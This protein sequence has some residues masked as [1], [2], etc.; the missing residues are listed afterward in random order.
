MMVSYLRKVLLLLVVPCLGLSV[1]SAENPDI[2]VETGVMMKTRDGVML[3]TD[4]YRPRAEGKYPVILERTSY[5]KQAGIA[6]GVKAAARGYVY[7]A[8]D[9]RGRWTSGGDGQN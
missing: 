3:S 7:I 1:W 2:K 5:G 8:Q 6:F 4:I 9:I